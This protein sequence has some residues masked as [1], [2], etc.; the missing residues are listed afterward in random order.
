MECNTT[1]KFGFI[2]WNLKI[3]R[4]GKYMGTYKRHLLICLNLYKNNNVWGQN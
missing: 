3:N 4:N 1:W 2:Q